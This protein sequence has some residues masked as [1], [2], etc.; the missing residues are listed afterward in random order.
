MMTIRLQIIVV[1]LMILS[2]VF[3]IN[4]VRKKQIE[5]KRFFALFVILYIIYILNF[6]EGRKTQS[7][8]LIIVP[9]KNKSCKCLAV[10]VCNRR[11][12]I[13]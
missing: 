10:F 5:L 11:G 1:V 13:K 4:L 2:F 8:L 7:I 3:I 9:Q 12:R 6:I